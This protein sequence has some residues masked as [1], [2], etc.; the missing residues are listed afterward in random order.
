MVSPS[1]PGLKT[2][3]APD[4]DQVLRADG[5]GGRKRRHPHRI[6]AKEQRQ[7]QPGDEGERNPLEGRRR[8][9]SQAHW[10]AQV[11]ASSS[12]GIQGSIGSR[13]K[14]TPRTRKL[15]R[16]AIWRSRGSRGS[17]RWSGRIVRLEREPLPKD[18]RPLARA[19]RV[20]PSPTMPTPDYAAIRLGDQVFTAEGADPIGAVRELRSGPDPALI[21]YIENTGDIADPGPRDPGGPRR[22][23]RPRSGEARGQGAP[24]A[25][26]RARQR[27]PGLVK[28]TGEPRPEGRRL[29]PA[30]A[31]PGGRFSSPASET[32]RPRESFPHRPEPPIFVRRA[33]GASRLRLEFGQAC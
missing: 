16:K 28:K 13:R 4:V 18:L 24:G 14:A 6:G 1:I 12:G 26:P 23:G 27:G 20:V 32:S 21:I 10:T 19:C 3:L 9:R 31:E 29:R 2:V 7:A 8:T 25:G 11:E 5:D 33:A 22:E 30:D 17:R 15:A